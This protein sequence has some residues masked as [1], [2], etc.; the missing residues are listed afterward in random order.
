MKHCEVN[1]FGVCLFVVVVVL[2]TS[3]SFNFFRAQLSQKLY[4][5]YVSKQRK[6]KGDSC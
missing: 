4:C 5:S 2:L 3:T 1:E 6:S